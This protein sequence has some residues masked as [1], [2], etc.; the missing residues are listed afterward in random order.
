MG[1]GRTSF[2]DCLL[3]RAWST[4][5]SVRAL[6]AMIWVSQV[7]QNGDDIASRLRMEKLERERFAQSIAAT[8]AV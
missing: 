3:K 8:R 4:T 5:S 2:I 7:L 6:C 1:R